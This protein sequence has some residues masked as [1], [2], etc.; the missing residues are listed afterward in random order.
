MT[1]H[2]KEK[3]DSYIRIRVTAK[4]KEELKTIANEKGLSLTDLLK[5]EINEYLKR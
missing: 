4:E 3:N 5:T 2:I 1:L